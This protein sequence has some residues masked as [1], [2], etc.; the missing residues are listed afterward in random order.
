MSAEKYPLRLAFGVTGSIGARGCEFVAFVM[1]AFAQAFTADV[2][3][4]QVMSHDYSNQSTEEDPRMMAFFDSLVQRE[5]EGWSSDDSTPDSDAGGGGGATYQ[6]IVVHGG[7]SS[8]DS[9]SDTLSNRTLHSVDDDGGHSPFTMAF[10]IALARRSRRVVDDDAERP[11]NFLDVN[12]SFMDRSNS[13]MDR[14]EELNS[15]TL[16]DPPAGALPGQRP[17]SARKSITELINQK[18]KEYLV[19]AKSEKVAKRRGAHLDKTNVETDTTSCSGLASDTSL[20]LLTDSADSTSDFDVE[21]GKEKGNDNERDFWGDSSE[22]PVENNSDNEG[23]EKDRMAEKDSDDV[24]DSESR[25]GKTERKKCRSRKRKQR[26]EK[27]AKKRKLNIMIG[28]GERN[29]FT[30]AAAANSTSRNTDVMKELAAERDR[31]KFRMKKIKAI[32]ERILLDT[33]DSSDSEADGKSSQRKERRKP[34]CTFTPM[35]SGQNGIVS[36]NVVGDSNSNDM[37]I[38]LRSRGALSNGLGADCSASEQRHF[39]NSVSDAGIRNGKVS[40]IATETTEGHVPNKVVPHNS[41]CDT[42]SIGSAADAVT[43]HSNSVSGDSLNGHS[44]S[45]NG[46]SSL[47]NGASASN[48]DASPVAERQPLWTEFKRF[49]SRVERARRQ[50]RRSSSHRDNSACSSGDEK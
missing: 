41:V 19:K 9:N 29:D 18:R 37:P 16:A 35:A 14:L 47:N 36:E 40:R 12:S 23:S 42:E 28:E 22:K 48:E 13:F 34:S 7:D 38:D 1:V 24:C 25:N 20:S 21:K 39:S 5:L 4:L 32:R 11:E 43:E 26:K 33:S 27:R 8:E 2:L 15:S 44:S 3:R 50:Y 49:R 46:H 45:A 10:A 6:P 30:A 17:N 31:V